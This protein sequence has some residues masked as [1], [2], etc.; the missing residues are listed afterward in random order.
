MP[1]TATSDQNLV[2]LIDSGTRCEEDMDAG[3]PDLDG[4]LPLHFYSTISR[5]AASSTWAYKYLIDQTLSEALDWPQMSKMHMFPNTHLSLAA[6]IPTPVLSAACLICFHYAACTIPVLPSSVRAILPPNSRS[7]LEDASTNTNVGHK[8][9]HVIYG[10][11]YSISS[12]I[13]PREP[14]LQ[15]NHKP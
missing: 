14:L 9:W 13:P 12:L 6:V 5:R 3:V 11:F 2:W 1:V 7:S 4:R 8:S 15:R 10:L